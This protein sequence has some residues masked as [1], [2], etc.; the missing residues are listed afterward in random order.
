MTPNAGGWGFR[1]L[2]SFP[3]SASDGTYPDALILDAAGN[4]YG[5]AAGDT[6]TARCPASGLGCGLIFKL[7][8]TAAGPWKEAVLHRFSGAP[9]DGNG[10]DAL[11]FDSAGNL[12]GLAGSGGDAC[13]NNLNIGCGTFYQLAPTS[14]GPWTETTLHTFN[15]NDGSAPYS[16]FIDPSGNVFGTAFEGG[17]SGCNTG[18]CGVVFELSPSSSAWTDTTVHKFNGTG[19]GNFPYTVAEDASGKLYSAGAFAGPYSAGTVIELS[20]ASGGTWSESVLF[21]F[22]TSTDGS[23][24]AALVVDSS[25]NLY[26]AAFGGGDRTNNGDGLIFQLTPALST[27]GK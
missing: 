22:P 14:S 15:G 10:P 19:D 21:A 27:I 17:I 26:G 12:L 24:P 8:P 7:S 16:F 6:N 9:S 5:A 20:P 11:A 3:A 2:H 18:R 23:L 13:P 25:G 4:I 1:I